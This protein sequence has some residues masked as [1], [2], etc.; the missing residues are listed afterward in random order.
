MQT[1]LFLSLLLTEHVDAMIHENLHHCNIFFGILSESSAKGIESYERYVRDLNVFQLECNN[2]H[3]RGECIRYGHY[4]RSYLVKEQDL[5]GS[6]TI[7]IQ[8]VICKS[9]GCTHAILPEKIVPY[10]QFSIVFILLVL[11]AYYSKASTVTALCETMFITAPM[12][13]RWKKQFE[14]QKD[15]YLGVLKSAATSSLLFIEWIT[16]RNDYGAEYASSFLKMTGRMPMQ[17]HRN[18][19]NTHQ[20]T[21]R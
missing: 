14:K 1:S 19:S 4:K 15:Q 3:C 11:L 21:M 16:S 10:C 9:C 8:R 7:R 5:S 6:T 2:C 18:P 12:L 13:Y 17:S 20:P